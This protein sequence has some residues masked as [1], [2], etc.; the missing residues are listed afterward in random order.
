MGRDSQK[1]KAHKKRNVALATNLGGGDRTWEGERANL[2][3]GSEG[4]LT[5]KRKEGKCVFWSG[6]GRTALTTKL[7]GVARKPVR[8]SCR[9]SPRSVG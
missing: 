6:T 5:V 1:V 3:A 8:A 2:G 7:D 4:N 9:I